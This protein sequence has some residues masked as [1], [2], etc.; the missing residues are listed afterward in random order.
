MLTYAAPA[1]PSLHAQA[2]EAVARQ[3]GR[4]F[5]F[6]PIFMGIGIGAYFALPVEPA[7][8]WLWAS[9]FAALALAVVSLRTRED[10][11]PL[12]LACALVLFGMALA[13]ARAHSVAAPVLGARSYGVIE[14][15]VLKLDRS[16]S[17][18]I[19]LT[20]DQVWIEGA[21]RP[22]ERVRLSLH[23][24]HPLPELIP[25]SRLRLTGHLGPPPPP[26]EPGGFDFRAFAWFER[27]GGVG[28]TRKPVEIIAPPAPDEWAL[29]IHRMRMAM[30]R[31]IQERLP[32]EAGAFATAILTGDRS[33]IPEE[34]LEE[35]RRSN[36]AHLLA[37]SG[38][39]M[40]LLTGF[41]FG[42][43]RLAMVLVPW[44]ALRLP[45]RKLAAFGAL[46]AA[47]FYLAL[48]G[49]NVATQRAF[50]MVAVMLVAVMLD[51]QAISLRSVAMAAV[52]ILLI[53]PEALTQAGFQMS[54]AA[55]IALVAVFRAINDHPDQRKRV[56]RWAWPV[57]SV[58]ICSVV[59]GLATAPIAAAAFNRASDYGLLANLLAVPL[60]G[61]VIM[62]AAVLA[63]VLT[64]FGLEWVG[65]AIMRPAILWILEVA[66]FVSALEGAVRGIVQPAGWVL[67]VI[68]L[69]GLWLVIW[70]GRARWAGA[71]VMALGFVGWSLAERPDLL[72]A[73]EGEVVGVLTAQGR[74]L[75]RE[76]A[77]AFAAESWLQADGDL[78]LQPEAYGLSGQDPR[79][80]VQR[81]ALRDGTEVVHLVGKKGLALLPDLC[82][83][84]R[85]VVTNQEPE[86]RPRGCF[87]LTPRNL[88]WSG[89]R[90]GH[91]GPEGLVWTLSRDAA[92]A[93]L[94]TRRPWE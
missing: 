94:W 57:L 76:T 61:T 47:A 66:A 2:L 81:L 37:I 72:I 79:A 15:R 24:G 88:R 12:V 69:G 13:G 29:S 23:G 67:P 93:R 91:V 58:V 53:R 43:L 74:A 70:Q 65:L 59:A 39:H 10:W 92:G 28:Y 16:S 87:L 26:A 56:P 6:V 20:L 80:P 3:R 51:R 11:A 50:V 83:G 32:G 77:G 8:L 18:A 38:L 60:M 90:A 64:P 30:S 44:V 27:L 78:R 14:G 63:A 75:S 68:C 25:G 33:A 40:G 41:V 22:P 82:T 55:T 1:R 36:L 71:G 48:S 62:P 9:G 46:C 21:D 42:L 85:I 86:T 52:I 34:R 17:D 89:A 7:P 73:R 84:G 31:A 19:R 45:T 49:G 4:L 54:F 35:L 5:L